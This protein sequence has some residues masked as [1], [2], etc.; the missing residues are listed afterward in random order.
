MA[1]K[2]VR[3]A[4]GGFKLRKRDR[5]HLTSKNKDDLHRQVQKRAEFEVGILAPEE[6]KL[7]VVPGL[8]R[9]NWLPTLGVFGTDEQANAITSEVARKDARMYAFERPDR[10]RKRDGSQPTKKR[11]HARAVET[12]HSNFPPHILLVARWARQRGLPP[13]A[14][15]FDRS[16]QYCQTLIERHYGVVV[17]LACR[18]TP[19]SESIRSD[20][21]RLVAMG[22]IA[23]QPPPMSDCG[24]EKFGGWNI[25]NQFV[26]GRV[27]GGC[28]VG[29][30]DKFRFAHDVLLSQLWLM[31]YGVD[32]HACSRASIASEHAK[33]YL[34]GDTLPKDL[35]SRISSG[36]LT[37]DAAI[38]QAVG[39]KMVSW[40]QSWEN[41]KIKNA[42]LCSQGEVPRHAERMQEMVVAE[43]ADRRAH[44]EPIDWLVSMEGT[45]QLEADLIQTD[46]RFADLIQEAREAYRLIKTR[47]FEGAFFK[48]LNELLEE[49]E[50]SRKVTLQKSQVDSE[51]LEEVR[52]RAARAEERAITAEAA[53]REAEDRE[54]QAQ[55]VINQAND[56]AK[57][58]G[59]QASESEEIAERALGDLLSLKSLRREV[60]ILQAENERLRIGSP[61]VE[62]PLWE[63][64]SATQ[65]QEALARI[66]H[67][68][69]NEL[70][71]SLLD[72]TGRVCAGLRTYVEDLL[73]GSRRDTDYAAEALQS[74][75]A[76]DRLA[77][78][79]TKDRDRSK[80]GN[81]PHKTPSRSGA[82]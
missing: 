42:K 49:Y 65:I 78:K 80:A 34:A 33:R 35:S 5:E 36:L 8:G 58:S 73:E 57:A 19:N 48:G 52:A 31:E 51:I 18:H 6:A 26:I 27:R 70:D 63:N 32:I 81:N 61:S 54:R 41:S 50:T 55:N 59:K 22:V 62:K 24:T 76:H 74:I 69:A 67:G 77:P 30:N 39:R 44:Q 1:K 2:Q 15:I 43:L 79:N 72:G 60:A 45:K 10:K 16:L 40:D 28:L 7:E 25:H 4:R 13:V 20:H 3:P 46:A 23:A 66:E 56:A 37:R 14:P 82:S 21:E 68:T 38:R 9:A 53:R 47:H 29:D 12:F 11:L 71:A 17:W 64:W 75:D